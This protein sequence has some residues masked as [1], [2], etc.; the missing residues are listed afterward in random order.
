[1][2]AAPLIVKLASLA[3]LMLQAVSDVPLLFWIA[4]FQT[5]ELELI[6][7]K[8]FSNEGAIIDLCLDN[9]VFKQS[10]AWF[11]HRDG[12]KLGQG[13]E[14]ARTFLEENP[15]YA[16]ACLDTVYNL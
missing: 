15:D 13:R 5:V 10:G 11:S 7:G 12:T 1:M 8:G 9:G 3:M 6:Y 16:Q 2:F 4:P 14:A